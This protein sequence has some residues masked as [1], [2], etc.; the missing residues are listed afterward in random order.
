MRR[1]YEDV[2]KCSDLGVISQLV[3]ILLVI[4]SNTALCE[5]GFSACNRVKTKLRNPLMNESL[6]ALLTILLN[7]PDTED[8][9]PGPPLEHWLN[10]GK[11]TRHIEHRSHGKAVTDSSESDRD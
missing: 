5:R 7:G 2:A 11:G 6:N 1:I 8:F 4:P 9:E 3:K 10:S